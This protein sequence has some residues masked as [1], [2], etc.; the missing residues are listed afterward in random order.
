[1]AEIAAWIARRCGRFSYSPDQQ[2]RRAYQRAATVRTRNA[3]RNQSILQDRAAGDSIRTLAGCYGLS[4]GG[5]QHVLRGA[6][7]AA[8]HTPASTDHT[9]A[10]HTLDRM[11]CRYPA[12]E[13]SVVESLSS[14]SGDTAGGAGARLRPTS[15]YHA[16]ASSLA[17]PLTLQPESGPEPDPGPK[18]G[19]QGQVVD[20]TEQLSKRRLMAA[21]DSVT[22]PDP[23][24][25]LAD[26]E[27]AERMEAK[28]A[29]FLMRLPS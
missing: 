12:S 3:E 1:M 8:N 27:R 23:A 5:I 17:A 4:I 18:V 16:A 26:A 24:P 28:R 21:V 7:Q 22:D 6:Q 9:A 2:R 19:E 13:G 25:T 20:V 10:N 14:P 15:P 29:E 11:V